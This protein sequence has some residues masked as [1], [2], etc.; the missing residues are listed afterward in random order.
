MSSY[1]ISPESVKCPIGANTGGFKEFIPPRD[2]N[3]YGN[4]RPKDPWPNGA[5]IA[6]CFVLNCK[7]SIRPGQP[8]SLP[9]AVEEGS[10]HTVWNGA[11]DLQLLLLLD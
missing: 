5:K 7:R 4:D 2:F 10:E 8:L 1:P 11:S 6:V 9:Y 3:G